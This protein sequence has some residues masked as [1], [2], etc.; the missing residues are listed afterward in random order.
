MAANW[1][2]AQTKPNC[3][4]QAERHL[5]EQDFERYLPRETIRRT[6]RGYVE[7]IK[8]PLFTGYLFVQ[9]DTA[10]DRWKAVASTK[11]ITTLLPSSDRPE[12]I[13]PGEVARLRDFEDRG[14]LRAGDIV[15]GQRLNVWRGTLADQVV[16]CIQ[17][18]GNRLKVLWSCFGAPR[19]VDVPLT[20]VTVA[21]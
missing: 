4:Q 16:E 3:E 19:V 12:P 1:F 21:A 20:D 18:N 17:N 7:E 10:D 6:R 15:P 8:R 9:L 5:K 2:V 13:R 14:L 11:G